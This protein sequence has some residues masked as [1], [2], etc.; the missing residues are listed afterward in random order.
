MKNSVCK[1][2]V[3]CSESE[4]TIINSII[5]K[6]E[7]ARRKIYYPEIADESILPWYFKTD[8]INNF[9]LSDD[10]LED[11]C[12][13]CGK[14]ERLAEFIS[15]TGFECRTVTVKCPCGCVYQYGG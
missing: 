4:K 3:N 8:Y 14:T 11:F 12:P 13:D 1:R 10:K 6:N 15:E 5:R 9:S 2:F 7:F